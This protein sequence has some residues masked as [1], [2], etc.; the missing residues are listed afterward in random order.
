MSPEE[1]MALP[2]RFNAIMSVIIYG[3]LTLVAPFTNMD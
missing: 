1:P 3:S 2:T